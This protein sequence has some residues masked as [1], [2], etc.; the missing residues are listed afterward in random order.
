MQLL[1]EDFKEAG[2]PKQDGKEFLLRI[3]DAT[4]Y[5]NALEVVSTT[6]GFLGLWASNA[7]WA[8][9]HAYRRLLEL[10]GLAVAEEAGKYSAVE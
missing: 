8:Y 3:G 10:R 2:L 4:T 7:I 9:V 1:L 5:A 6:A